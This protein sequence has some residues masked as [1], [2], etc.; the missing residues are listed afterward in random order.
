[1]RL[2]TKVFQ[3]TLLTVIPTLVFTVVL[4][5]VLL[6]RERDIQRNGAL[7]RNRA[8]MT[9]VDSEMRGHELSLKALATSSYL[10]AGALRSFHDEMV[11]VLGSQ[12][13]W[14]S[15]SLASPALEQILNTSRPYGTRLPMVRDNAS[16]E[17]ALNERKPGIG[18]MIKLEISEGYGIPVRVPVVV[19]GQ[20]RYV[21][22]AML[23]PK[24][25]ERLIEA[26]HL[27][28]SWVSGLVDKNGTVIARVP[29][30]MEAEKAS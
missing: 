17:R 22:T 19:D 29:F 12:P 5:L 4:A 26:Q 8:F 27:P 25:F 21:L 15:I 30:R 23:N 13:D 14:R 24:R 20:V 11:R 28:T 18:G 16:F 10:H 2:R 7:D 3:L 6:E 1:M 9:A